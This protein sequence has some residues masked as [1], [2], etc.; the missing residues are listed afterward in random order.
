VRGVRIEPGDVAAALAAHPGVRQAAAAV[1]QEGPGDRPLDRRLIAYF[2]AE[3]G[4]A[5]TDGLDAAEL[6]RWMKEC[7][8]AAMV[9]AA[10]VELPALP[11]TASG[12][13]DRAA[14]P[15]PSASA[16]MASGGA[17]HVPP[18]NGMEE[19]LAGIWSEL[20]GG[21]RVGAH[22]SFFDLGGHSLQAVRLM[23]R[24]REALGVDLPVRAVFEAP[25]LAELAAAVAAEMERRLAEGSDG[26]VP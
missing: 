5:R 1:R 22:D 25:T 20:L 12:K 7:L 15:A 21:P 19:I 3:P 11:L 18:R 24:L 4:E 23:N 26:G 6:R 8:P 16:A 13:I 9:P 2:V 14:L 10:F 17:G